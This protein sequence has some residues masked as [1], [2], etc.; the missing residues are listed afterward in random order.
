ITGERR[1]N[2]FAPVIVATTEV[3]RNALYSG[4]E[5]PDLIILDE[6]HY[7]A[8]PERGT[9]WEEI[10]ILAPLEC[11]LLLL[12][13]TISNAD[14]IAGW[15]HRVR[16][17]KPTLVV[18]NKRPVPLRY[19]FLDTRG[20]PLPL[21]KSLS[22]RLIRHSVHRRIDIVGIVAALRTWGLLPAI[23]FLP[24]RRDCD[25]AAQSFKRIVLE[26]QDER[27]EF[28][29]QMIH[30]YPRLQ[31]HS[32]LPYLVQAGVAPHHAG[33]LT[34]WKVTVERM[35][36]AG[37]VRV[38]FAT[39]TLAAGLDVPARTVVLPTLY[40]RDESGERPLTAL[41]FHQMTGRA[42]RRGKDKIGFVLIVPRSASDF[43][44]ALKLKVAKPEALESAFRVQYYQ[45][46]NLL[47]RYG[48]DGALSIL[49]RSLAVYQHSKRSHR[50]GRRMRR[51]LQDEFKRRAQ[52]LRELGYLTDDMQLTL[53]GHWALLIRHERSLF[54]VEAIRRHLCDKLSYAELAGWA[55]GFTTERAPRELVTWVSLEPLAEL[56]CEIEALEDAL[57]LE[58][59]GF[60]HEFIEFGKPCGDAE[61]RAACVQMWAT[62]MDWDALVHHSDAEEGDVQRLV[63]QAAEVLRQMEDLPMPIAAVATEARMAI[64]RPPVL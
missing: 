34:A 28:V 14:D 13:A 62:G 24:R 60:S 20:R 22:R 30:Q 53:L 50:R 2:A 49:E 21:D 40:I 19:G 29:A 63:L 36:R 12:S 8:D 58:P 47:A 52:L 32:M 51:A 33:H 35:L 18:R 3:L 38:V 16:H 25:R 59:S 5:V 37:L 4:L 61:R 64:M 45:V 27:R 9:T 6:A 39:T 7:I 1:E 42:G 43:E 48:W 11:R 31:H 56:A 15:M 57:G 10:V 54:I 23:I 41:E 44:L 17:H 55:A 46:L 26:G